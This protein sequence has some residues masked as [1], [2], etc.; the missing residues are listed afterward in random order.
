M[1]G[2]GDGQVIEVHGGAEGGPLDAEAYVQFVALGL[3]GV[4]RV[5]AM[6]RPAWAQ[7]RS[8]TEPGLRSR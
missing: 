3:T 6:A 4:A 7:P 1:V 8:G 2:T 5:L